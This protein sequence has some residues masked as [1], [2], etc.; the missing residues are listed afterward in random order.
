[1]TT[2]QEIAVRAGIPEAD[3]PRL[4]DDLCQRYSEPTRHYHNLTHIAQMLEIVEGFREGVY[5]Y[6]A[7]CLAIWFHDAIY[8]TRRKDNEE[9][10]AAYA[11]TLLTQQGVSKAISAR[12]QQLILATKTHQAPLGDT[13]CQLLLDADLAILG[14]EPADYNRYAQAIRREYAWVSDDDYRAGRSRVLQGFLG[15]PQIYFTEPLFQTLEQSAR[16]NLQ[17]EL[18]Q[19]TP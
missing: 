17:R 2:W 5:D 18:E 12:V 10:S 13:D 8:D 14:S 6:V 15:R 3:A 19:L 9:Q 16:S 7:V 4:F 1:M 11:V